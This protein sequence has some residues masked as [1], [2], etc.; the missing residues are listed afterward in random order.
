MKFKLGF[1]IRYNIESFLY[2]LLNSGLWYI[3]MCKGKW[4]LWDESGIF[5]ILSFYKYIESIDRY[6]V[7]SFWY[8][9]IRE[10]DM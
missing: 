7:Y 1:K 4:S 5:S 3:Y 10:I 8:L 2:L 6:I 9:M